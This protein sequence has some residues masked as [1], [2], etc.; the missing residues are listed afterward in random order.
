MAIGTSTRGVLQFCEAQAAGQ[1]GRFFIDFRNSIL[2][3]RL[4]RLGTVIVCQ[5]IPTPVNFRTI[6][7]YK[8]Y[9]GGLLVPA[10]PIV[11]QGGIVSEVWINWFVSAVLWTVT[12]Y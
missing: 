9:G 3:N 8:L 7:V 5:R 2:P 12:Y 1:N 4:Q 11:A 6:E 10:H